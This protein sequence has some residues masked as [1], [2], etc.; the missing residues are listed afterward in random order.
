MNNSIKDIQIRDIKPPV[1]ISDWSE[2]LLW[3]L[4]TLLVIALIA[5]VWFL[6]RYIRANKKVDKRKLWLEE[7]YKIDWSNPKDTAYRITKYGRLLSEDDER[8]HRM[9]EHLLPLLEKYKYRKVVDSADDE[10]K[11]EFEIFRRVCDESI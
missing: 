4:A 6:I 10:V 9:Y 2:Y 7:L 11:R 5:G 1:E 3:G 8:R